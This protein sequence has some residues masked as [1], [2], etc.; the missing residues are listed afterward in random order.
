MSDLIKLPYE[1]T[2]QGIFDYVVPRLIAQGEPSAT[3]EGMCKYRMERAG[4]DPL[5]C[6]AG[7]LIPD[8]R[9]DPIFED[10]QA[11]STLLADTWD[12]LGMV[13]HVPFI[14]ALQDA[15]DNAVTD[16]SRRPHPRPEFLPT[17]I[18]NLRELAQDFGLILPVELLP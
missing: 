15:H 1:R 16:A 7:W 12:A 8:E 3:P 5:K 4:L 2:R 18:A 10:S 9:Y 13:M 14:F 6:A 11:N 17:L